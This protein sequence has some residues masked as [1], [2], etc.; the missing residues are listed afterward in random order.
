M[1]PGGLVVRLAKSPALFHGLRS[2]L[3]PGQPAR[4]AAFLAGVSHRAVLE[5]GCGIGA[6]AAI[7]AAPYTG[8]D[9]DPAYTAYA[10]RRFGGSHRR[11]VTGDLLAPP[12]PR[13][14]PFDLVALL[15][16]LHHLSDPEVR[17]AVGHARAAGA[18]Q[19]LVVDVAMERAGVLFHRVFA[20][21]DRGAHFRTTDELRR[22]LEAAGVTLEREDGWSTGWGIWPRAAFLGRLA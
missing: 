6:N 4:V 21:L 15:N 22:L 1:M 2:A 18:K 7:T 16:V 20:P 19:V 3:D 8:L 10:A 12:D 5:L 14:G 17:T 13:L 11:F 9:L